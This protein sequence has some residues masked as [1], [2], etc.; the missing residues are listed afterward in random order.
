MRG[1]RESLALVGTH[2][3]G[4]AAS[5]ACPGRAV[6]APKTAE[7]CIAPFSDSNHLKMWWGRGTLDGW[8]L[9]RWAS[10]A[11]GNHQGQPTNAIDTIPI[12]AVGKLRQGKVT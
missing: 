4:A 11:P 3:A 5:W 12:I 7:S 8:V 2:G 10:S 9:S 6:P 1:E